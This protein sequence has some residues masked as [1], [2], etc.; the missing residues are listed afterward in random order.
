[1]TRVTLLVDDNDVLTGFEV[2]GHSGFGEKG[3][4]IV[5]AAVSFLATNTANALEAFAEEKPQVREKGARIL[6]QYDRTPGEKAELLLD[7]FA[8]GMREISAE[9]GKFVQVV[10]KVRR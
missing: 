2:R 5:C 6:C 9:Y 3:T 4:D 1:M 7:T 8:L 10:R